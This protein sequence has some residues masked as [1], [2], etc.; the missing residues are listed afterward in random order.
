MAQK[1][2]RSQPRNNSAAAK[3][4]EH[5]Q[6]A[7]EMQ[8]A[9]K[10]AQQEA[11][12]DE[13]EENAE[14]AGDAVMRHAALAVYVADRN[15]ANGSAIPR[16]ERRNKPVQLAVER[17]LFQNLAAVSFKRRAK[18]V[19]LHAAQLGHQP[20]GDAGRNAAHP[21]IIDTDFAPAADDVVTGG[22]LLQKNRDVRGIVLQIAIHGDD[23]FAARV[24]KSSGKPCGLSEV[25]A[26]FHHRNAAVHGCD[27]AQHGEGVIARSI[28]HEHD[29]EALASRLHYH[30]Q[31]VIKI[32]DILV[33]V[34]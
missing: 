22:D 32:G 30:L 11:N 14:G 1:F 34:V 21:E 29:F 8:R 31:A 12:G 2:F 15:F 28:V 9:R 4:A 33:L 26:Q 25:A 20:V 7:K 27:F 18:V 6:G 13:I 3:H 17:N 16:R 5:T 23:V 10:I 19:N 24:I